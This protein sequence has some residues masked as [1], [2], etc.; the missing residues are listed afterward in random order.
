MDGDSPGA[1]KRQLS[2]MQKR[3]KKKIIF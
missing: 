1:L 2:R 3:V